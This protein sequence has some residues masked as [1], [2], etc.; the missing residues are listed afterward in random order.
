MKNNYDFLICGAGIIGTCISIEI[1]KILPNSSILVIDKES[2]VGSHGSGRNSGVLHAG[3]YY[4]PD[5]LKAKFTKEGNEFLTDYCITKKLNINR[6]GKLVVTK[7]ADDLKQLDVL[8]ERGKINQ[9][10]IEEISEIDAKKLEPLAKTYKKALYSP[11]TSSVD[12][13]EVLKSL[14]D[15]ARKMGIDYSFQEQYLGYKNKTISTSKENYS[16]GHFINSAGLYADK[17]A[18]QFGFSKNYEILPFKGLYLYSTETPTPYKMHIYPVP[19]LRNPFLGVHVTVTVDKKAKLGPTAIPAFWRENYNSLDNFQAN[20]FFHLTFRQ[21][22]LF[23]TAKF[24]FKE[25]AFEEIKKHSKNYMIKKARVLAEYVDSKFQKWGRPGIRAQLVDIKEKKLVQ[26]FL[27]EGDNFSTH[28]LNAVSPAFT[29]SQ[30]F[31]KYVVSQ[32]IK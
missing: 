30:P 19:D 8:L 10:Q 9:I 15:E 21:M 2:E 26:D 32:I 12:P 18:V 29:C 17:I 4:T 11:K 3:F 25:L 22:Q 20:E 31:S 16:V 13:I 28:V 1:K 7:D 5:S 23:F 6:C 27:I 14:Q 24:P